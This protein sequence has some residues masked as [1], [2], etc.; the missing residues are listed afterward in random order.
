ML[1]IFVGSL[2]TGGCIGDFKGKPLRTA[3]AGLSRHFHGL[4]A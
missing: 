1:T 3:F 2:L 4:D